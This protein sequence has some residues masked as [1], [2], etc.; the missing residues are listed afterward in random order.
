MP[1]QGTNSLQ[2]RLM[3]D[4]VDD[5]CISFLQGGARRSTHRRPITSSILW[6]DLIGRASKCVHR[7]PSS[8][9]VIILTII[10]IFIIDITSIVFVNIVMFIIT[11][12]IV[13]VVIIV[14]I[15][16]FIV[17]YTFTIIVL[18]NLV[19][20]SSSLFSSSLSLLLLV[21]INRRLTARCLVS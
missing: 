15:I 6:Y 4:V 3:D 10:I 9:Y 21:S 19:L 5:I 12:I 17:I 2:V 1:S 13:V 14:T 20:L 16:F 18:S 11:I 7:K 8:C